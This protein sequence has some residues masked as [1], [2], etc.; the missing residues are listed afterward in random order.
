MQRYSLCCPIQFKESGGGSGFLSANRLRSRFCSL[1]CIHRPSELIPGQPFT[2]FAKLR[3][4]SDRTQ[5]SEAQLPEQ[6]RKGTNQSQCVT[7]RVTF[8]HETLGLLLQ[9]RH[10]QVR[11]SRVRGRHNIPPPGNEPTAAAAESRRIS[12]SVRTHRLSCRGADR[13]PEPV[14]YFIIAPP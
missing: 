11:T 4:I 5:I 9:G 1:S 14:P 6:L 10:L 8:P 12:S 13:K 2:S 3:T 7:V